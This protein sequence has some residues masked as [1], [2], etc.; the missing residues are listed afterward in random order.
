MTVPT[1]VRD[2][3]FLIARLA[4]GVVFIAHG[5][6]KLATN[7]IDGTAAFLGQAGVPLP[8]LAAWVA[9][10]V[11]LVGGAAL[12]LG[13]A[14]PVAAVLLVVDM[15]GA[16]LFVHAGNGVYV[17]QGGFELVGALGASCLVLAAVGAGRYGVDH[18][19][20]NRHK[21]ADDAVHA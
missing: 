19:I 18:V 3:A 14:L 15:I 7:G 21:T 12:V 11:E 2:A 8:T 4:V 5:W 1:H 9:A 16:Y 13:A 10:L 17:D 6:Q 20:S